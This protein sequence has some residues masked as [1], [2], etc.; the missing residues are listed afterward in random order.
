[1]TTMA[2]AIGMLRLAESILSRLLARPF[3]QTSIAAD[4]VS[5]MRLYFLVKIG[6]ERDKTT[7][8]E[9]LFLGEE[10]RGVVLLSLAEGKKAEKCPKR[11]FL[12]RF[13]RSI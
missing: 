5:D 2:D 9:I 10:S 3:F 7:F 1:M 12:H 6:T 11:F 4:G 13:L 8:P